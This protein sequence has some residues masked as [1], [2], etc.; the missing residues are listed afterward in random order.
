MAFQQ[1]RRVFIQCRAL[2]WMGAQTVSNWRLSSTLNFAEQ[3]LREV[4]TVRLSRL[5]SSPA[6]TSRPAWRLRK[7]QLTAARPVCKT[8][9]IDYN[10]RTP[11]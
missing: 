5:K 8:K 2:I 7:M 6:S 10:F 3:P 4:P 11:Q 1:G 9:K